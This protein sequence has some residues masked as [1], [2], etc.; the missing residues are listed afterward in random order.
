MGLF[1]GL[2][3]GINAE[4]QLELLRAAV[5]IYASYG[6]TTI[7]DGGF[8][9]VD[10]MRSEA[11]RVP[12]AVDIVSYVGANGLDDAV[13]AT[14]QHEEHYSWGHWVGGVKFMLDGSPQGRIA[15]LT[16]PYTEGPPRQD[17]EYVAYPNYNPQAYKKRMV[18]LLDRGVPVLAHANGDAAID[19]MIDG[20]AEAVAGKPMPDHRSVAIHAQLMR[21]DQLDRV[22]ELGI[23]PSYYSV[24]PF[25]W[26]DWHRRSFGEERSSFISPVKATI[27]RGI[28]F[29]IHNDSP[30][31]PPDMMRLIWI[32]VNRKTRSGYVL[33]PDQRA[34]VMEDLYAV[35]QR[36]AY[37]YFEED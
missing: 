11:A 33:G 5:D 13:L 26:G 27:E 35:T 28:P 36:A 34:T 2:S 19:L 37:Q 29:T 12:F 32:T 17:S 3:S 30:V 22:K 18:G 15:W 10:M 23:I 6:I 4:R 31:V 1:P 8:G 7:Q 14:L 16:K 25:F 20:V 24:H 9:D 21:A